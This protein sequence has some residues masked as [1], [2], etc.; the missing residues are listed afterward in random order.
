MKSIEKCLDS[1]LNEMHQNYIKDGGGDLKISQFDNIFYDTNEKSNPKKRQEF[2]IDLMIFLIDE[3]LIRP[4]R[5]AREQNF[6]SD[7]DELDY[8][9]NNFILTAKGIYF[10]NK[11]WGGYVGKGRREA[12][13][14]IL[15]S[16]ATWAIVFGTVGLLILEWQKFH[17]NCLC[18]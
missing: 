1:V 11:F 14:V 10:L 3:K 18:P 6:S 9:E 4:R 12:T 15:R 8:Y 17:Q 7:A 2:F 13:L 5:G 16:V